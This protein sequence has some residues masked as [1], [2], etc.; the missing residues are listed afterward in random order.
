M[1]FVGLNVYQLDQLP[2][3]N[4]ISEVSPIGFP[5]QGILIK[6]T[7]K[8]PIRDLSTGV[9][10]YSAIE[11]NGHLYYVQEPF[12]EVVTEFSTASASPLGAAGGDLRGNYPNPIVKG[13][14]QIPVSETAPQVGQTLVFNGTEYILSF[15]NSN[16][17]KTIIWV[18]EGITPVL[19]ANQ[20]GSVAQPFDTP[21]AACDWI[22]LQSEENFLVYVA[23][24]GYGDLNVPANK[25]IQFVSSVSNIGAIL[26]EVTINGSDD[27]N[28]Q[29][30]FKGFRID[31]IVFDGGNTKIAILVI[32]ESGHILNDIT[33]PT[34]VNAVF[35][36]I[37][38][39]EISSGSQPVIIDG[40]INIGDY[41]TIIGWGAIYNGAI[42]A[43]FIS[44]VDCLLPLSMVSAGNSIKL[45]E[46]GFNFG[47]P[48]ITFTGSGSVLMDN[49]TAVSFGLS[50]G[51]IVN[52]EASIE[53]GFGAQL[54]RA[55]SDFN[56]LDSA[57]FTSPGHI[58]VAANTQNN[59]TA[60]VVY[61][62]VTANKLAL[63]WPTGTTIPGV[64]LGVETYYRSPTTG[65]YTSVVQSQMI[66]NSD[67][68]SFFVNI[69]SLN[70]QL[71]ILAMLNPSGVWYPLEYVGPTAASSSSAFLTGF[72]VGVGFAQI[73]KT[74]T[75]TNF[76][77][78]NASPSGSNFTNVQIYV[79]PNGV[80]WLFAFSGIT[81]SILAGYY[82]STNASTLA[83]NEGDIIAVFNN[84]PI[85]GYTP[86]ALTITADLI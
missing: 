9:N 4:L 59:L 76:K 71:I 25:A 63:L 78:T 45:L 5:T 46:S 36:T 64:G 62:P 65:N 6:D 15:L 10:V 55:D 60:G 35:V 68:Q 21:Q 67:G 52:G 19:T 86:D 66:G 3:Y 24:G 12:S 1:A 51:D 42:T 31:N 29:V 72:G 81:L 49:E 17:P 47:T 14:Q 83:V 37:G 33:N 84:D 54:Y 18:G 39:G 44:C 7:S 69:Q 48:L 73:P 28:H 38:I 56:P 57:I 40:V 11:T 26:G 79:A 22:A 74:G 27:Y 58:D 85:I 13:I 2:P 32:M 34:D 61:P 41:G 70:A 53:G 8:S 75:L 30:A 77:F 82:T 43:N 50:E 16:R 20:N 23:P 80:P